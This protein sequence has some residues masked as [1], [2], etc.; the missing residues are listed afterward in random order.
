MSEMIVFFL[1]SHYP[2]REVDY[3]IWEKRVLWISRIIITV[4]LL[5][6]ILD[7]T[8]GIYWHF[9]YHQEGV[10]MEQITKDN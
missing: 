9:Q 7:L 10:D 3:D 2:E 1:K 6:V 5:L 4:Y 8:L